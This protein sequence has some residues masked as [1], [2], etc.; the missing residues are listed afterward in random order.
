MRHGD[1]KAGRARRS[2]FRLRRVIQ[3]YQTLD[4]LERP[5]LQADYALETVVAQQ[6]PPVRDELIH[7]FA[8]K[9]PPENDDRHIAFHIE[10]IERL[11]DVGLRV[12]DQKAVFATLRLGDI[13]ALRTILQHH[14]RG[15]L[16]GE[17][18]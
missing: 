11:T 10:L 14:V 7:V 2:G 13:D 1:S 12:F 18:R 5:G 15:G 3:D 4:L 9:I 6:S 8:V 17:T 16:F